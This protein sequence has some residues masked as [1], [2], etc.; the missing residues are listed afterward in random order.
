MSSIGFVR[1]FLRCHTHSQVP[2]ILKFSDQLLMFFD[3]D[4]QRE[5]KWG[6]LQA[7]SIMLNS[8]FQV[9]STTGAVGNSDGKGKRILKTNGDPVC[10][11]GTEQQ[12]DRRIEHL[13]SF[14]G[15]T[16]PR[17]IIQALTEFINNHNPLA[18]S[19]KMTYELYKEAQETNQPTRFEKVIVLSRLEVHDR[20]ERQKG[21]DLH[22][23][24]VLKLNSVSEVYTPDP[25]HDGPAPRGT[26]FQFK[27][28]RYYLR[29][30]PFYDENID[31]L[32]FPLLFP[33]GEPDLGP[34]RRH[35]GVLREGRQKQEVSVIHFYTDCGRLGQYPE[36]FENTGEFVGKYI[37]TAVPDPKEEPELFKLVTTLMHHHCNEKH[38]CKDATG[39]CSRGFPKIASPITIIDD[40][41]NVM[42]ATLL[43]SGKTVHLAFKVAPNRPVPNYSVNSEQGKKIAEADIIIWD[44]VTMSHR[45]LI[46]SI[47]QHCRDVLQYDDP[48]KY[49]PFGGKVV[50]MS[51][52]WKQLLP[53]VEGAASPIEHLR[54]SFKY[55]THYDDFRKLQ[56]TRNMR[57]GDAKANYRE[58]AEKVGTGYYELNDDGEYEAIDEPTV[59]CLYTVLPLP[60]RPRILSSSDAFWNA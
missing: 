49:R 7:Q 57:I 2:N 25:D 3:R 51:G 56:L 45:K 44:E 34:T 27:N 36:D 14:S 5:K 59:D 15:A 47:Q 4:L 10:I 42:A 53:V 18:Q 6:D 26:W 60:Y 20:E 21:A 13:K 38:K 19:F 33:G 28:D 41:G 48:M 46:D 29:K 12:T 58:Y 8:P 22:E 55:S 9:A 11:D 1:T 31:P 52:D 39:K 50:L 16:I 17:D 54:A 30:L 35:A 32:A 23:R 37:T 40:R 24:Q 43:I